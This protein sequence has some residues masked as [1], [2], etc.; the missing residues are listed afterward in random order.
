MLK[1]G[2]DGSFNSAATVVIC[3][4]GAVVVMLW[5]NLVYN[6]HLYTHKI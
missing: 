3:S 5:P 2:C 4:V 1:A 6:T